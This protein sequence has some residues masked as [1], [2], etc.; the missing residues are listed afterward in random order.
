MRRQPQ[1]LRSGAKQKHAPRLRGRPHGVL[2]YLGREKRGQRGIRAP[3]HPFG[4]KGPPPTDHPPCTL[5]PTPASPASVPSSSTNLPLAQPG[6]SSAVHMRA[7]KNATLWRHAPRSPT[8]LNNGA[9]T[10]T[11]T[12]TRLSASGLCGSTLFVAARLC[13]RRRRSR[14]AVN[15]AVKEFLH[16]A[17]VGRSGR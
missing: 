2:R 13:H 1:S 12:G 8:T 17:R 10:G 9:G 6:T 5:A 15:M 3:T 4:S 14:K 16:G 7:Q 11:G